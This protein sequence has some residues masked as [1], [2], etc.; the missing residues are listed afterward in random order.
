MGAALT[1]DEFALWLNLRDVYWD[2]GLVSR[3]AAKTAKK[4][5]N[6]LREPLVGLRRSLARISA[7]KQT[8]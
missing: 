7:A 2:A 5:R 1:L 8:A 4:K 3:K 6:A